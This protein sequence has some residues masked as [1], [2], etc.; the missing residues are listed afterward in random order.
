MKV[1]PSEREL[2]EASNFQ[3]M[4]FLMEF[5]PD[6]VFINAKHA[7]IFHNELTIHDGVA[8]IVSTS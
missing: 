8:D 1:R 3:G 2:A 4:G 6:E 7:A 5:G